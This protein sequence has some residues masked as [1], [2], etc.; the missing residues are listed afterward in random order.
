MKKRVTAVFL[1][2]C[3]AFSAITAVYADD[4]DN[5]A[6]QEQTEESEEPETEPETEKP[7]EPET[8]KETEK[9]DEPETEKPTEKPTEK[10]TEKPTEAKTEAATEKKTETTTKS[11]SSSSNTGVKEVTSNR[12]IKIDA[13]DTKDLSSYIPSTAPSAS[14]F[15]WTSS[16]TAVATISSSG[17]L[18][19]KKR[20]VC[21]VTAELTKNNTHYK[22]TF[23]VEIDSSSSS[24]KSYTIDVGETKDLYR[25]VDD[26]Y[27]ASK[28]D[29]ESSNERYVTVTSKGVVK[30][31]REG[32]A[33]ITAKYDDLKY[34]FK[35]TVDDDDDDDSSSSSSSSKVAAK[36]SWDIYLGTGDKL[37]ISDLLEDDPDE[38]DWTVDDDDIVTVDE[39]SGVIRGRDEGKTNVTAKGDDRYK[40]SVR[41]DD[42]Y[43]TDEMS[44]RGK[45]SKDLDDYLDEDVDEYSF[46]S[47]RKAV[48]TVNSSGRV[49]GVANGVA[50]II[51]EHEDGDIIQIF[52]TVS[53]ISS[54]STTERTTE[55]TTASVQR[56]T[57][58]QVQTSKPAASQNTVDFSDISHR[59]WAVNAIKAMASKGYIVGVGGSRFSPDANCKRC[60]FTIV[61]AKMLNLNDSNVNAEYNDISS[62]NYYYSYVMAALA[63]GIEAGV[64]NN[65][66][67][68]ND[69]ITREEVMVMVYKGLAKVKG[70]LNTDTSVL[71]KYTDAGQISA[72]NKAAVAALI[73]SGAI[74]GTSATTLEPTAKITRAQMAV[75]MQ[76]VD[77]SVN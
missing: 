69:Y 28:Y 19:G 39:N 35:I 40:F 5:T 18:T 71:S 59:A 43:S 10:A 56:A 14:E 37:D 1:S 75:I 65:N 2:F 16:N 50:S 22:Y 34:S 36:L 23:D 45:Q 77:E 32:S 24:S 66:F 29:W 58:S 9:P 74:S 47:D 51:C 15:K 67:R 3:L 27:T 33:T 64:K 53:G 17:K 12:S 49:T 26:S 76:K 55:A 46:T 21:T 42:K 54:S 73:N 48:A 70:G 38:Y 4:A 41:V 57:Q 61:L 30:G 52:V 13:N 63:N 8:E 72:E 60:D 44:I 68:P 31:V 11:T 6:A 7:D 20:G 62:K 25:Y